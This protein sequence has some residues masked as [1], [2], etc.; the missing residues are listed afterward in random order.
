MLIFKLRIDVTG[1]QEVA[2]EKQTARMILF[3]GACE[4]DFFQGVIEAGGVDTQIDSRDGTGTLSARYMLHGTD[5]DGNPARVFIENNALFGQVTRPRVLTDSPA[6]RFL[7]STPL[8][9]R[10]ANENGQLII[11]IETVE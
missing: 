9:G 4:G 11:Y 3:G 10:I 5:R 2:G 7:E 1:V 8:Q 6:L